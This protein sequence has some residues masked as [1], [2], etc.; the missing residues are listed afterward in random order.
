MINCLYLGLWGLFWYNDNGI[1]ADQCL[2]TG[3]IGATPALEPLSADSQKILELM[4]YWRPLTYLF[5]YNVYGVAVG[6]YCYIWYA[7]FTPYTT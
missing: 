3:L 6:M 7:V 5:L 2:R 4:K 1:M